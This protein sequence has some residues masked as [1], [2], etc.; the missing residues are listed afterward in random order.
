MKTTTVRSPGHPGL[1]AKLSGMRG[2]N[3]V[4]ISDPH[5]TSPAFPFLSARSFGPSCARA[6]SSVYYSSTPSS[7]SGVAFAACLCSLLATLA[8]YSHGLSL[9]RASLF[10]RWPGH[11]LK[12]RDPS[13]KTKGDNVRTQ[14]LYVFI[15]QIY[16]DP[17]A[18]TGK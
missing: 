1:A 15:T 6:P 4:S 2:D 9:T 7:F 10:G 11:P 5:G 13:D 12:T 3:T 16:P 8:A 14:P 17:R 18:G